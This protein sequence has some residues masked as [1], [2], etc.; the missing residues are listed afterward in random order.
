MS[1]ATSQ[2]MP[3]LYSFRRCPY[4]MRARM[5]LWMSGVSIQ[6]REVVLR[7]KPEAMIRVSPKATVPVLVLP[8]GTVLGESIDIMR[9]AL[10]RHDPEQW[11]RHDAVADEILKLIEGPFKYHLDRYKYDT[12]YENADPHFHRGQA[13]DILEE[14]D[15]RIAAHGQLLGRDPTLADYASFPFVR[16]FA[17]HDRTWFDALPLTALRM[18]LQNHLASDIFRSVMFKLAP[19][20]PGDMPVYFG[21]G[22]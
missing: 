18:W 17:H 11:L 2:N 8:D 20:H 1:A 21:R 5:A 6:L 9:W 3:I 12:R 15:G 16:Q 4:A 13:L 10:D 22:H 7:D 14:L 19:W